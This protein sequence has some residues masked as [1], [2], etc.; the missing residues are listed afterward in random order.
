MTEKSYESGG[1]DVEVTSVSGIHPAIRTGPTTNPPLTSSSPA[2]RKP[3]DG[4]HGGT[5]PRRLVR[6]LSKV[7]Q[8]LS[9]RDW[10]VLRSVAEHRYLSVPHI[11]VLHFGEM[12]QASGLR[13]TQRVLAR[14]RRDRVLAS[15]PARIGGHRSGSGATIH[16]VDEIGDRLLRQ[17]AER[18]TRR[19]FREPTQRFLDH[20]L[21]IADAHVAF[22]EAAAV[23][24]LELL[25]CETEP[26]A[27]RDYVGIGG[28]RVTLKPDLYAE[29]ASPPGS[30]YVDA[31]FMEIDRGT[32]SIPTLLKK[33]REYESYRRQGVEQDR[34]DGAFP[35]V[36]WVMTAT[37]AEKAERRRTALQEA[38]TKDRSLPDG[39]FV[40]IA[41][42]QLVPLMQKGAES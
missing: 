24:R 19:P 16:Y 12:P 4:A 23:G 10:S 11:R 2:Q 34:N 18:R 27:W 9:D 21:G 7:A 29:T 20:Q 25:R 13:T 22:V 31:A 30:D 5:T 3:N 42:E 26:G 14:L 1:S 40:A 33:C 37:T 6:D 39:L 8:Q 17:Q 38:I 28:A 15:L 36:V 41:P 35:R 32:E